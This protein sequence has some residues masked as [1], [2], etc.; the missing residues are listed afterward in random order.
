ALRNDLA[1]IGALG[2]AI[3]PLPTVTSHARRALFAGE[4]P[5]NTAIDDTESPAANATADQQAWSRNTALGQA[6]RRLVLKGEVGATGEPLL[7]TLRRKDVTVVAAVLNGVDDALSS[8]ETTTMPPWSL[9]TLGAGAATILRTAI[10]EG[11][12]VIVTA[13]HG[14]TPFV[15]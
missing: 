2:V 1:A 15:A 12:R 11:W 9:A 7:K 4:I 3:S 14:H 8:R 10:D 6:S 5:G 13:D